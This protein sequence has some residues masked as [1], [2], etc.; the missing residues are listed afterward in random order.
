[1]SRVYQKG[2]YYGY[3]NYRL[4][5]VKRKTIAIMRDMKRRLYFSALR[6]MG[7]VEKGNL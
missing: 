6:I 2:K 3:R 7:E 1:M 5:I 4:R